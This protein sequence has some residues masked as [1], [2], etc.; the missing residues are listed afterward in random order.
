MSLKNFLKMLFNGKVFKNVVINYYHLKPETC[1]A[2][3]KVFNNYDV[4]IVENV[5]KKAIH[6]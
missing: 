1:Y 6:W 2:N 4:L 3:E 5:L